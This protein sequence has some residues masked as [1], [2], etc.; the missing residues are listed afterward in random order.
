MAFR[1]AFGSAAAGAAAVVGLNSFRREDAAV[2]LWHAHRK[3]LPDRIIL[4]RHGESEGNADHSL[5]RTKADNL[6][7]LTEKGSEQAVEVGRRIKKVIGDGDVEIHVSPFQRSL[8]TA[9]NA[10]EAFR[11]QVHWTHVDSRIREQ[12]FGNL[13]GDDFKNFRDEQKRV[14]RF[15][16]R[17]PTG[18]SGADVFDRTLSWWDTK[19]RQTT[20]NPNHKRADAVIVFTHGL[21][22]RLILMQLYGWSPRTFETVWNAD[23]CEMYVLKKDLA[24]PWTFPYELCPD[25]GDMPKST[26]DL[27]LKMFDGDQKSITLHDYLSLPPPRTLQLEEAKKMIQEQH[28]ID[29]TKIESIDFF[30]GKFDKF[31]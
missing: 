19:V 14:G 10:R 18:E 1:V 15:F 31:R 17:F 29:P 3:K 30:G 21:T 2:V 12:E 20:L 28:G 22:M 23:N 4:V 6:I 25:E 7:E 11:N 8:Q 9:R 26:A 5:Y 16:Y 27:V 13:Q 24:L